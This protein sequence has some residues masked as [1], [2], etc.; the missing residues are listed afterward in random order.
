MDGY[1]DYLH[2]DPLD[3]P[4]KEDDESF[5]PKQEITKPWNLILPEGIENGC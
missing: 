1:T 2:S 4:C 5:G 3:D